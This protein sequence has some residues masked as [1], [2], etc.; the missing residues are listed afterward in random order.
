MESMTQ[1]TNPYVRLSAA[2]FYLAR[3]GGWSERHDA[4]LNVTIGGHSLG[5]R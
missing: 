2:Q 1:K 5:I 4:S 3:R